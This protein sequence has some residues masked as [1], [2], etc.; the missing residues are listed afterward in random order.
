MEPVTAGQ[1]FL[2]LVDY[3][4][5]P[6]AVE[7]ALEAVR[8]A[9]DGR[10]ITVLGA[11]GDRD[12]EK[13]PI[14]GKLAAARSDIL[15][16]TDDN[17][18]SESASAIREAIMGGVKTVPEP[19]RALTLEVAGRAAAIQ[20]AVSR[21][22]AGDLVLVLGKGHEQGVEQA[23]VITPFDDRVEVRR[24][25]LAWLGTHEKGGSQ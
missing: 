11:G 22:S 12:R 21:A 14:M 16:I 25:V 17:P 5:T 2:A 1:P 6:D 24:A 13:R 3:A 23:G 15:V 4:H 20:E 19:E 7:R 18:R 8:G 10:V 9:T